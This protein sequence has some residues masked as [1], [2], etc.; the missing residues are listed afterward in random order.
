MCFYDFVVEKMKRFLPI[1]AVFLAGCSQKTVPVVAPPKSK[2]FREKGHLLGQFKGPRAIVAAKDG[3]VYVADRASRISKWTRDG[4]CVLNWMAPVVSNGRFEGPEGITDLPNGD[5]AVTNTHASRVLIYSP[6]GKLK[7]QFGSYGQKPGQF[8]LVTGATTDKDG[9]LY[10]ADYGGTFDRISKWTQDGKLVASWVGHGQGPRQFRRPCGLAIDKNGDLLVADIGNHRIQ[11]L[12]RKTGAFKRQF[13][14]RGREKGQLTYPY[15][16][17]VD[18][19][20]LIYTVEYN[21][22][23]VQQ[24]TSDGKKSLQVW[25]SP[26]NK[27]GQLANPWGISVEP[28]GTIYIADTNND[29]VQKFKFRP[30]IKQ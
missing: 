22:H 10:F 26:G 16:V 29:R 20:G 9:F 11:V 25:G 30:L 4:K 15:G 8:I 13:G 1:V 5:I 19:N 23:R 17:A 18:K 7:A 28:D 27:P 14:P 21:N 12:D 24:W 2:V 3:F 6:Q